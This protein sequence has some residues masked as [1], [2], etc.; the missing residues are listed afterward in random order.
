M[1]SSSHAFSGSSVPVTLEFN[2]NGIVGINVVNDASVQLGGGVDVEATGN[3]AEGLSAVHSGSVRFQEYDSPPRGVTARFN[4]NK[5]W[6]GITSYEHGSLAFWHHVGVSSSITAEN[7]AGVGLGVGQNSSARFEGP[8]TQTASASLTF[9]G[10]GSPF[11]GVAVFQNS[12]VTIRLPAEINGNTNDGIHIWGSCFVD[13]GV[14]SS[15]TVANNGRHGIHANHAS[16]MAINGAAI[17]N[18]AGHGVAIYDNGE[19]SVWGGASITGN[20]EAG[21]HAWNGVGIYLSNTTITGNTDD[22]VSSGRGSRLGWSTSTVGT[23]NCNA[24]DTIAFDDA[25]CPGNDDESDQ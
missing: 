2:N 3:G 16:V 14:G 12:T 20:G 4:S 21:I 10:N 22:D 9:N 8:G 18:N 1:S 24:S 6:A 25:S 15:V 11:G 7:N 19:L 13:L 17:E 23:V 5:G